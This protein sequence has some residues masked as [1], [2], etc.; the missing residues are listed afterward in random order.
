MQSVDFFT[1]APIEGELPQAKLLWRSESTGLVLDGVNLEH[2][3]RIEDKYLLFL[4][5]NCPFEEGLHIYLIDDSRRVLDAV[6][7][8]APYAPGVLKNVQQIGGAAMSFSFFGE[9]LWRLEVRDKPALTFSRPL[10]P[11]KFKRGAL[12]RHWLNV[13]RVRGESEV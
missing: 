11:V 1:L 7:I 10:S 6:E 2:Q 12:G 8:G 5:E 13:V 9:D 4:T 3:V